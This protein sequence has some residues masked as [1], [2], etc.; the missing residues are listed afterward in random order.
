MN[1][2]KYDV[3]V[4]G[5]SLSGLLTAREI[6]S[7]S[8][9]SVKVLE[10]DHEI[11]TPEHCGGLVSLSGLRKLGIVPSSRTFRTHIV[12][13]R[14]CSRSSSFIVDANLQDVVAIDRRELDK[15]IAFQAQ[16]LGAEITT[17]N[18]MKS[19][20]AC[21][22]LGE[23]RSQRVE[24]EYIYTVN[25]SEGTVSCKYFVDARGLSSLVTRS[26]TGILPSGQY[27][28][29]AP[30][31]DPDTVELYFDADK[32][33]GF[34]AWVI[35]LGD[36]KA[37]IGVACRDIN[38]VNSIRSFLESK[39]STYSILRKIFAPIYV[40]GPIRRFI[41][42]HRSLTVGDAAGQTKPTTAGGILSSG[43]GGVLAGRA[44][45][46]AIEQADD[47]F[48]N[49]YPKEWHSIFGFEFKK[50]MVSRNIFEHLYNK[51]IDELFSTVSQRT[52]ARISDD[53]QF[54]FHSAPLSLILDA[55]S[56]SRI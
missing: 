13:A 35:P 18:S 46:K 49:N 30:W 24:D 47:S 42:G 36:N 56:A 40:S 32:Y 34:F 21:A 16:K 4:A 7:K 14:I 29:F 11:G 33:P 2:T 1:R 54:D 19:V 8:S 23:N 9:I 12:R 38:I 53:G 31:I 22:K 3:I 25:T 10:A 39:G 6:V 41:A 45:V 17:M 51:A 15:Q 28:V 48:L 55:K 26:R 44:I 52:L 20:T 50:L 27:E 5:G 37:K 43:M